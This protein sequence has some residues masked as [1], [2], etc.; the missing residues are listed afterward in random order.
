MGFVEF[1]QE[2]DR[3][4]NM[5][6]SGAATSQQELMRAIHTLKGN[7]AIFGVHSVAA[8]A[9]ELES[10]MIEAE[11]MPE[12]DD[13]ALLQ[14]TWSGF[15]VRVD[16]LLGD[17][18]SMLEI[19]ARDVL[20][21]VA[22]AESRAPHEQIARRLRH[23]TYEPVQTRFKRIAERAQSLASRLGKG[24]IQV[25]CVAHNVRLPAERWTPFSSAF[26]HLIRNAVDHGLEPVSERI[27]VG[28]A[29]G[30]KLRLSCY[31]QDDACVVEVAD[32]GRGIDW[33][34]LADAARQ[35]GLPNESHSDLVAALFA[36]GVS[37]REEASDV[38]GRG[39]GMAALR[40]AT[41]A[42]GGK[43]E[44]MSEA[45]RGTTFRFKMPIG[46]LSLRPSAAA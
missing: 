25:E 41:A 46:T 34:R 32:D 4:V 45:G 12:A 20:S 3:L 14:S 28:K 11:A 26:V 36:D 35:R 18:N 38:S 42:M 8:V 13:L 7:C 40:E 30:G 9:H 6:H 5:T 29:P 22:E 39:V 15:R 33:K 2:G 19:E 37:T 31:V 24:S 17:R 1:L 16:G 23:L 43:I 10:Y 21:I 44:V 27:N